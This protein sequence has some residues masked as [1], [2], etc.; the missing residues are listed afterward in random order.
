M[1][2]ESAHSN[3]VTRESIFALTSIPPAPEN[4]PLVRCCINSWRRAGLEVRAFNHP[5]EV[6]AL[7]SLYDVE[8]VPIEET[9]AAVFK[10]HYVPINAMI[11]WARGRGV[12]VLLINSDI[13]LLM[14]GWEVKRLRWLS[15]GGLCYFVRYNHD[16]NVGRARR[17]L[18]GID[19]FLFDGRDAPPFAD[20]FLSMGQ[21]FWDYWVPHTFSAY[22]R[23][24]HAVEFPAAFHRNHGRQWSRE[25]WHRCAL[26][27]A[28]LTG[29]PN[30][31]RS[32]QACSAMS[33][34]VR[35]GLDQRKVSV[36][37]EPRQI[38]G[39]MR[40][41]F[42]RPE[43]KT[44]LELS[45]HTGTAKA[46]IAVPPEVAL[47]AFE[48]DPRSRQVARDDLTLQRT[49]LAERDGTGWLIQS[50]NGWGREWAHSSLI[51]RLKTHLHRR[52]VGIGESVEVELAGLDAFCQRRGLGLIDFIRADVQGAEGEI[53]RGGR[54]TLER[55]RY[56]YTRY[57]DNE[58]YQSH[59]T[60]EQMLEILPDFRVVELW[61]DDVLLENR[62]LKA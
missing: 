13:Q 51:E 27:F 21:P 46:W 59:A 56:L 37:R 20:S 62:A 47:H 36:R 11:C 39:W 48:P 33:A 50:R 41:T 24:V 44:F 7:K 54:R 57:S 9:T 10:K 61:P 58:M 38:K 30:G 23:P 32:T 5:S 15:D 2:A 53:M 43:P 34:R 12:P 40:E 16:G 26:E 29:E 3:T 19:A 60:L 1:Y 22:G 4:A 18:Y 52:P 31:D 6:T 14:L 42:S 8:F 17:E 35:A 25:D 55:T 45:T 49:A 28:R